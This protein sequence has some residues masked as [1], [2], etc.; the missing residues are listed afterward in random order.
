ML[1]LH[2]NPTGIDAAISKI[3]NA[4]HGHLAPIWGS[5][6]KCYGRC[7][8]NRNDNGYIAENYEGEGEYK[9]VYLDDSLPAISFFGQSSDIRK[10]GIMNVVDFHLAVFVNLDR[11]KPTATHRADEE[12]RIDVQNALGKFM[13]GASVT[14]VEL[15]LENVLREYPGSRREDRLKAA[16]MHPWHCFRVNLRIAYR[17]TNC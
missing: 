4:L 12:A 3:Q 8:R 6:Y 16:D 15:W 10:E 5:S 1:I 7:Y 2:P 13:Y 14:S 9:E 17:N 11:V